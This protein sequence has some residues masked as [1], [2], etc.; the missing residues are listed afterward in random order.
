MHHLVAF[1][2]FRER[3]REVDDDIPL[4]E[5]HIHCRDAIKRGCKLPQPFADRHVEGG[6][7]LWSD[8]AA[9]FKSMPELEGAHRPRDGVVEDIALRICGG[10]VVAHGEP[11]SQQRDI[12]TFRSG[13]QLC[14]GRQHRPAPL[15]FENGVAEHGRGYALDGALIHAR[16]RRLRHRYF[17]GRRGALEAGLRGRFYCRLRRRRRCPDCG[18]R[19]KKHRFLHKAALRPRPKAHRYGGIW[20]TAQVEGAMARV[21]EMLTAYLSFRGP[22]QRVRPSAGPVTGSARE[23]GIQ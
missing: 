12:R 21:V 13:R 19:E 2:G 16:D 4:A 9:L 17:A 10:K 1:D 11:P 3:R 5:L 18:K 20:T 22:S 23:P 7:R 15:H 8:A 6:K 14:P